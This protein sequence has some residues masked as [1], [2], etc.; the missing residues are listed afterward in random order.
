MQ[1]YSPNQKLELL[2][3]LV[4]SV[5]ELQ[6]GVEIGVWKAQTSFYLLTR[7]EHLR[8][9]GIDPYLTWE[10]ALAGSRQALV[11]AG[12]EC[13]LWSRSRD[14]AEALYGSA[15]KV[16][17]QFSGRG[18]RLERQRSLEAAAEIESE[19][20]DFVFVDGDHRYEAVLADILA[21]KPKIRKGGLLIGDDFNW[22]GNLENVGRAVSA[23]FGYEYSVINDLWFVRCK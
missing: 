6:E 7:F 9:L 19:S 23:V 14:R 15:C 20:L 4:E 8:Y 5:L 12:I 21:Y 11:T 17:S 16:F 10:E 3:D 1:F 13:K 18:A 2:G 22:R